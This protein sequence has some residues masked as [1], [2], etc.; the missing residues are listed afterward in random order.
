MIS[1]TKVKHAIR[2][3]PITNNAA[4]NIMVTIDHE[5][6]FCCLGVNNVSKK[7]LKLMSHYFLSKNEKL[8]KLNRT[9]TLCCGA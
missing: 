6:S 7:V 2:N 5:T 1:E 3:F 9:N 4:T 8:F